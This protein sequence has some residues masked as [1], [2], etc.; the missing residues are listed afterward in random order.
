MTGCSLQP[1]RMP[2]SIHV[3]LF[4]GESLVDETNQDAFAGWPQAVQNLMTREID[5]WAQRNPDKDIIEQTYLFDAANR[6]CVMEFH[7][8][9]KVPA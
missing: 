2:N 4:K 7:Y 9:A 1:G 8:A 3:S 6:V 5:R